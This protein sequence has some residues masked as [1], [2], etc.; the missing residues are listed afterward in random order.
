MEDKS[1]LAVFGQDPG[2]SSL[3]YLAWARWLLGFPDQAVAPSEEAVQLARDTGKPVLIAIATGFAGLT[4]SMRRDIPRLIEYA[5]ECLSICEQHQFRQHVAMSNIMLGYAHSHQ[6]E[7][8][9]ATAMVEDGINEKVALRSYIALPWF[10]YLAA[11]AYV[12][13]GQRGKAL[14]VARKGIDFAS[15][16]GERFFESENYRML[17]LIL[18]EDPSSSRAEIEAHLSDALQLARSQKA[19]SLEL[20]SA[21]GFARFLHERGDRVR[22]RELLSPI[23]GSFTEGLGTS[24]LGD[25]A[26][27]IEE[28]S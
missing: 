3:C 12:A 11:E 26:A 1:G 13:A 6:G 2:L 7:H 20:R 14:E 8:D 17:A 4:Y 24:D 21:V 28:L 16:G 19:K 15:R 10:C 9:R 25:A 23:Y 18:A 5:E 27:L 22:A